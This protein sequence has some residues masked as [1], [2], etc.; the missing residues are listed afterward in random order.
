VTARNQPL[1]HEAELSALA[2]A[3]GAFEDDKQSG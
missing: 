2:G 3:L 1:A